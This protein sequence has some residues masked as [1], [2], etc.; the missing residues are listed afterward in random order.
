MVS[1]AAIPV[2]AALDSLT[3]LNIALTLVAVS[4]VLVTRPGLA[5]L[6]G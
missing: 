6:D 2:V 5:H 1:V 4:V 3:F